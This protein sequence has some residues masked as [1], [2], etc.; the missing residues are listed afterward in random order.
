MSRLSVRSVL[1]G[2]LLIALLFVE[3][4]HLG[5]ADAQQPQ[6]YPESTLIEILNRARMDR[7]LPSLRYEP[8]LSQI[9]S[10]LT[11]AIYDGESLDRLNAGLEALLREKGYPHIFYGGR[12][13]TTSSSVEEMARDWLRDTGPDGALTNRSAVEIGVAYLSSDGS[14]VPNIPQ[15]IW[16]VVIAEP[17]RPA[18][19][20]WDESIR[21]LVNQFR[22]SNGLPPLEANVFLARA[23]HAHAQDMVSRDFFDHISPSGTNPGDRATAAGYRWTRILEN[24]AAGQTTPQEV[25]NAWIRSKDG[26]REAMLDPVVTQIGVGYVF[27]PFDAG[28]MDSRHYWA[29]SLGKPVY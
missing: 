14:T 23:A 21:R 16:A 6:A 3:G 28:R 13:A 20:G 22:Y 12:Y 2:L 19:D 11:R 29:M 4:G 7:R 9:A 18:A 17:A 8:R 24:L 1:I 27:V 10:D 25:V 15:N 5:Q 26:H